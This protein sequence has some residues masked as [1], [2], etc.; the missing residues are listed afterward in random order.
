MGSIIVCG[1]TTIRIMWFSM[2]GKP[3]NQREIKWASKSFATF[4]SLP[5]FMTIF[6]LYPNSILIN[7]L[8]LL[9]TLAVWVI[10]NL[11]YQ[12]LMEGLVVNYN[13]A[14]KNTYPDKSD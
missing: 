2:N 4:G 10:L 5:I 8:G 6:I 14:Y 1:V 9:G 3:V 7:S 13:W 12:K 11:I